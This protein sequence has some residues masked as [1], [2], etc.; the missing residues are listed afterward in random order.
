VCLCLCSCV[1][2][3]NIKFL[4]IC[5][6]RKKKL[7]AVPRCGTRGFRAMEVLCKRREQG[8]EIDIWAAG[9]IFLCILSGRYPFFG[10]ADDQTG[11]C[12]VLAFLGI[13]DDAELP[14]RYVEYSN[15][16][17]L[18]NSAERVLELR[19]Y[20]RASRKI[21]AKAFGQENY[22]AWPDE[23]VDLMIRCLDTNAASRI[24]AAQALQHPFFK[25]ANV[26]AQPMPSSKRKR[27][28]TQ[29]SSIHTVEK[30]TAG[31]YLSTLD[32]EL[33]QTADV[34]G[35][36]AHGFTE[37]RRQDPSRNTFSHLSQLEPAKPGSADSAVI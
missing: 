10:G 1:F 17:P 2:Y 5:T 6:E 21:V 16:L 37:T 33:P 13:P 24:T 3:A 19:K 30:K 7:P 28:A 8:V 29:N 12:E 15:Q 18:R 4:R 35:P 32:A 22:V 34:L 31:S 14:D 9:V 23:A 27:S 11:L 26:S 36:D 25:C 20:V